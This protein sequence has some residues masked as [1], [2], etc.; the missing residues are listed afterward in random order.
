[1]GRLESRQFVGRPY[2]LVD[3]GVGVFADAGRLWAG[4]VPYGV[5]TPFRT[6][7]GVSLLGAVPPSSA[8]LWRIDLAYALNPDPSHRGRF[9]LRFGN[10]DKTTFFLAEPIDIEATRER[11]VPSSVFRWPK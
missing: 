5:D 11:T 3:L 4:D 10:Q 9:E 8:R 6:A 1:V 2:A 7:V